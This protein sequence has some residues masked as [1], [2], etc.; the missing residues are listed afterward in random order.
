M[1][2]LAEMALDRLPGSPRGDPHRFVVVALR[3]AGGERVTEPEPVLGRDL[4]GNVGERRRALV[5]GND[6][7]R[8][9]L[10]VADDPLRRDDIAADDVV[11][12]VEQPT[13][14]GP[15][16]GDRLRLKCLASAVGRRA[17]EHE[18]ALG[19]DRDD[20]R[21]LDH[22][23]LHQAEDLG[24]EVLAPVRPPQTAAGDLPPTQVD[25][26]DPR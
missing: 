5:G 18:S 7:I 10:V 12:D 13:E 23:R 21:V 16:T 17:L 19:A 22:L 20:Q 8:V 6:E 24:A 25:A 3:A 9:I 14:E 11:G 1:P 2:E 15:V 4:V 26:L